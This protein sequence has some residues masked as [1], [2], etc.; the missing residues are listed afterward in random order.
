LYIYS[1]TSLKRLSSEEL[2]K[3]FLPLYYIETTNKQPD[4]YVIVIRIKF[5]GVQAEFLF[6]ADQ[7][8]TGLEFF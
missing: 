8:P 5:I 6:A 4:F 2:E 1:P 7:G 3:K